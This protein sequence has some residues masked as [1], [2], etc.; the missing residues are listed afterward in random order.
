M[1]KIILISS[2]LLLGIS[3][4]FAQAE[5]SDVVD[6][7]KLPE[8]IFEITEYDFGTLKKGD[9]CTYDFVF[10]ND[11]KAD[12]IITN[13]KA[14][15]GCTTPTY[16]QEPV[17]KKEIGKISVKYDS[18]RV[19]SFNKTITVT[20]NAKNSPVV[21]SIKGKIEDVTVGEEPKQE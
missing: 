4:L 11:G 3:G 12:L 8:M 1:K 7:T 18:N 5:I 2:F 17:A 19:G 20:S 6:S 16:T 21:I 15:C 13:V 14:S 9:P 10:K